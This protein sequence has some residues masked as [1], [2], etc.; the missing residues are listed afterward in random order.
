MYNV[1]QKIKLFAFS[2]GFVWSAVIIVGLIFKL[3]ETDHICYGTLAEAFSVCV[4]TFINITYLDGIF[5]I[6]LREKRN[7]EV[8]LPGTKE[9]VESIESRSNRLRD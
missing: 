5:N 2:M 6:K 7:D 4:S 9:E 1:G 8:K 3:L